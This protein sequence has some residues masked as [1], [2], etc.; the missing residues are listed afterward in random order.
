M[1]LDILAHPPMRMALDILAHLPTWMVL[2]SGHPLTRM[3]GIF[4][5]QRRTSWSCRR[6]RCAAATFAAG[7]QAVF[8]VRAV[9]CAR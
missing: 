8:A 1:A 9:A 2:D 3:A 6:N 7:I 4:F 5:A